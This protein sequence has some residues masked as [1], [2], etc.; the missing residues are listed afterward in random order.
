M[1]YH[2]M[3]AAQKELIERRFSQYQSEAPQNISPSVGM[4]PILS[5]PIK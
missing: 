2:P 4:T 5:E 1:E 3:V